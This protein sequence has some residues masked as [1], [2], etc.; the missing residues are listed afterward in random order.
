[1]AG[2]ARCL[3]MVMGGGG[4]EMG[5]VP[6]RMYLVPV[7]RLREKDISHCQVS[8]GLNPRPLAEAPSHS[9]VVVADAAA[10]D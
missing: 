6:T 1:M 8:G 7:L 2:G 5:A 9:F 3:M 10:V 4:V